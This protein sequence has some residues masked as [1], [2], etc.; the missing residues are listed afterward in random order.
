MDS[1]PKHTNAKSI[2]REAEKIFEQTLSSEEWND[3]KVPQEK[4]YGIDYRVEQI[5]NGNLTGAEFYVQLKGFSK[6]KNPKSI[7]INVKVS[8]LRYWQCKILPILLVAVDCSTKKVYA[9][10]FDK[11]VQILDTLV[12]KTISLDVP[13]QLN[14]QV[15]NKSMDTYFKGFRQDFLLS[16]K[17]SFYRQLYNMT[18]GGLDVISR[19]SL[20]LLT[21]SRNQLAKDNYWITYY[22]SNLA[23]IMHDANLEQLDKIELDN[24]VEENLFVLLRKLQQI[25]DSIIIN[26]E[27]V[28]S[29]MR[30]MSI[31]VDIAYETLI[32]VWAI[33]S[34]ITW[35]LQG[36]F[37][38]RTWIKAEYISTAVRKKGSR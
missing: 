32:E 30:V 6:I 18:V 5:Q 26:A 1:L 38:G 24:L 7:K 22:F 17:Y 23:I 11:K 14:S 36:R 31:N 4:D 28:D 19:M 9:Q 29:G 37:L 15:L 2:Q 27:S 20:G 21:D 3:I 25:H 8:T 35:F 34:E 16:K 33:F 12:T 10:W 13:L